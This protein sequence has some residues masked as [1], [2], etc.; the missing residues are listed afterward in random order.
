M[1]GINMVDYQPFSGSFTETLVKDNLILANTTSEWWSLMQ[2][3]QGLTRSSLAVIKVGIAV[4]TLVW[5]SITNPAGFTYGGNVTG[6]RFS[7]GPSDSGY[8][9][10]GLP[11]GGSSSLPRTAWF[12]RQWLRR[13]SQVTSMP[14]F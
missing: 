4:G 2:P 5:G 7:S 9:A 12:E 8:F 3:D 10:F 6:N 13:R 1:G 14:R 11:V